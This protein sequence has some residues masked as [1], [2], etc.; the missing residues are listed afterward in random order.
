MSPPVL[1]PTKGDFDELR[2][3]SASDIGGSETMSP[4]RRVMSITSVL[5]AAASPGVEGVAPS[6]EEQAALNALWKQVLDP[7]LDYVQ[8]FAMGALEPAPPAIP[9]LTMI[10]L[11]E[12]VAAEVQRRG[13]GPLETFVFTLRLKMWPVFQKLMA[14]HADALKKLAEGAAAGGGYFRRVGVTTDAAVGAVC[15]RYVVL[16][17]AFVALTDQPEETMIFSKC[18]WDRRWLFDRS[19]MNI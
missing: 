17:N 2:S 11:T 10:R 19:L 7:V 5:G 18:V 1:S 15:R 12:D 3:T 16:F 14:E 9:L 6:K 8:T 4:R 13:C